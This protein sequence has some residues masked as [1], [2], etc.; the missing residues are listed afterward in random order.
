MTK[1]G[2]LVG[3]LTL[4]L[5]GC[6]S[7]DVSTEAKDPT[8][9]AATIETLGTGGT[10]GTTTVATVSAGGSEQVTGGGGKTA[11]S[12]PA[13]APDAGAMGSDALVTPEVQRADDLAPAQ[14]LTAVKLDVLAPIQ[15]EAAPVPGMDAL[16]PWSTCL[17][18][19][20][21][22]CAAGQ[23][24]YVKWVN[25]PILGLQVEAKCYSAGVIG[26]G[27]AN[28]SGALDCVPGHI[29]QQ[30]KAAAGSGCFK[31]CSTVR[32]DCP[33]GT[34]CIAIPENLQQAA[35]ELD[36]GVCQ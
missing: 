5:V 24:C 3:F 28:C 12:S 32:N 21:I 11:T 29:C 17:V 4:A 13:Q 1:C 26:P 8:N 22:G 33:S 9:S 19:E 7:A 16:P 27:D 30:R 18:R 2:L 35:G 36:L 14:D 6:A 20:N 31:A 23:G 15:P 34:K 10:G 25:D